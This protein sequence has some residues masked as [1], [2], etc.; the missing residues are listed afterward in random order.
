MA[1]MEIS[2]KQLPTCS[3]G[4]PWGSSCRGWRWWFG[5]VV[6]ER[7]WGIAEGG[8]GGLDLQNRSQNRESG[9]EGN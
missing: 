4:I 2:N 7:K 1:E 6:I 3:P 5:P 9:L 8:D